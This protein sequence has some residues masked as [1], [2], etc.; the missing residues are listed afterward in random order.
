EV[1]LSA[2]NGQSG[3]NYGAGCDQMTVFSDN[4]STTIEASGAPFVGTYKPQQPLSAFIGKNGAEVNGVWTL[5]VQDEA[6]PDSGAL[7]CWSLE[8][9]PMGCL[10]G[11]GPCLTPPHFTQDISDQVATND[12]TVH[13]SVTVQGADPLSY[14][15]YFN[16]TNALLEGTNA[17]LDLPNVSLAQAGVYQVMVTNLYGSVTSSPASLPVIAPA[18]ILSNPTD[19]VATNGDTVTWAVLAG[20]AAPLRYQWYFNLTHALIGET[21]SSLVLTNVSPE[22]A[23]FYDVVVSNVYASVTSVPAELVVRLVPRII[24]S[25]D[26]TVAQDSP[27]SF[28]PPAFTDTNLIL[29]VL[30]TTTNSLCDQSYSATRKWLVSDTNGY[31]VSCSQTVQVLDTVPPAMSCPADKTVALGDPWNFDLPVARD[32]GT[33][34]ALVYDN[35]TNHLDQALDPGVIEVGNQITLDGSER[36]P[37]RLA[38]EYWGTNAEQEA[39]AGLVTAQVRFYQ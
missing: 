14:Q 19:Q 27:W 39:F 17:T 13:W 6:A 37:G 5:R 23:G 35:W 20:G 24:C 30:S 18:R 3:Q 1:V 11:D 38:L 21:N 33:I 7:Q 9:D 10:A 2:N 4:A 15:W 26:I 28:I 22:Q 16:S 29:V 8:L 12:T 25:A 31:Q 36:Y 32:E 34:E